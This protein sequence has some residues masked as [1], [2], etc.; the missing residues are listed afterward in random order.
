VLAIVLALVARPAPVL[1]EVDKAVIEAVIDAKERSFNHRIVFVANTVQRRGFQNLLAPTDKQLTCVKDLL[2]RNRR[3]AWLGNYV[4]SWASLSANGEDVQAWYGNKSTIS[5]ERYVDSISL[6]GY[7]E[8]GSTAAIYLSALTH[9]E[10]SYGRSKLGG[11]T[12]IL[13]L[14][15]VGYKWQIEG[16]IGTVI[17][18]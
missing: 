1:T 13:K 5:Y 9:L 10:T 2:Q 11:K 12:M 7:S 17:A 6:P 3:S 15:K 16:T 18:Y 8:D 4:P 14:K